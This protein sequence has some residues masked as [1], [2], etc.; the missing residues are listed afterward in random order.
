MSPTLETTQL[1]KMIADRV[2][3]WGVAEGDPV[4]EVPPMYPS[5]PKLGLMRNIVTNLDSI[6]P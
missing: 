5:D 3:L 6:A 4:Q 1:W 2:A